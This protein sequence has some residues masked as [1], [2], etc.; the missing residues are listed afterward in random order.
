MAT[1]N[2]FDIIADLRT[3]A[4]FDGHQLEFYRCLTQDYYTQSQ[5]LF[6]VC[7]SRRR[8]V[9]HEEKEVRCFKRKRESVI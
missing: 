1:S 7:C 8:S 3:V 9:L 2:F 5:T 4:P 6:R